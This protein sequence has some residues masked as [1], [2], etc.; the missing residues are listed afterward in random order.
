LLQDLFTN[1]L[2]LATVDGVAE[3]KGLKSA[4]MKHIPFSIFMTLATFVGVDPSLGATRIEGQKPEVNVEASVTAGD[5]LWESF[6]YNVD[7]VTVYVIE[8]EITHSWPGWRTDMPAGTNLSPIAYKKGIKACSD[9]GTAHN[10][11][12]SGTS[13]SCAY[14][15]NS[16]GSFNRVG[17]AGGAAASILPVKYHET[18]HDVQLTADRFRKVIYYSG[19]SSN[20]IRLSYREFSDD[21]ARPAFT[22]DLEIGLSPKFPQEISFKGIHVRIKSADASGIKYVVLNSV[23]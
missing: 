15:D 23:N 16:S 8:G 20:T 19:L 12:M 10:T 17:A 13:F 11:W 9:D 2:N 21:I 1:T 4:S 18:I 5:A 6:G 22:Q 7:H 14:D 3:H